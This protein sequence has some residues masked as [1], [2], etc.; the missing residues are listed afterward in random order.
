DE[1]KAMRIDLDEKL[2]EEILDWKSNN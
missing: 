2:T 1:C